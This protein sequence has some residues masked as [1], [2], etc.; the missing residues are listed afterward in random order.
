MR[1]AI[2]ILAASTALAACAAGEEDTSAGQTVG[3]WRI[4]VNQ[5]AGPGCFAVRNFVNPTSEVQM[6]INATSTPPSGYLSIFVQGYEGI[7]PGQSIPATFAVGDREFRGTFTGQQT[8]GFGGATVPVDSA[9]F[10]YDLAN[11][12]SLT[13][14][15]GDD[16]RVIVPLEDADPAIAA[17]RACQEGL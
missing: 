8:E 16:R 15:Y 17:L 4:E 13:I 7:E 6:G 2:V 9:E 12:D 14:T 1:P 10:I 11:Q 5:A 3:Q